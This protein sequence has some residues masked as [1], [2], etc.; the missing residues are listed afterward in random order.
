MHHY[1]QLYD[2]LLYSWEISGCNFVVKQLNFGSVL[3]TFQLLFKLC[4]G[5]IL[6]FWLSIL[7]KGLCQQVKEKVSACEHSLY[8]LRDIAS[9]S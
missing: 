7:D 3:K 1:L 2:C 6:T 9:C 4:Q 5:L 8:L